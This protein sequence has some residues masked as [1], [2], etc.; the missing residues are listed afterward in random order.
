M[1]MTFPSPAPSI[2]G[3]LPLAIAAGV[4]LTAAMSTEAITVQ[5]DYTYDTGNY[6]SPGS[7][8]RDVLESAASYVGELLLDDLEAIVPD[9]PYL[10]EDD[11]NWP[12]VG[13]TWQV[14][15]RN[16]SD[17]TK[18]L[19]DPFLTV[20]A[21]T[22]IIFA[23]GYDYTTSQVAEAG[24]GGAATFAAP[25]FNTTVLTRGEVGGTNNESAPWG[26]SL[27]VDN[28]GTIWDLSVDGSTLGEGEYHLYSVMLHE[29]AHVLGFGTANSWFNRVSGGNF[30][31]TEASRVFGSPVPITGPNSDHFLDN[32]S[33][34]IYGTQIAQEPALSED[35][36]TNQIKLYT[37][38][39]LAALDD[40]GWDIAT[41]IP[42]PGTGALV[43]LLASS[44]TLRRR[45]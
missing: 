38:L 32:I 39:D 1:P 36:R 17:P 5:I 15:F 35:I 9:E 25:D 12:T 31:G 8:R 21:D 4:F 22:I 14:E 42:E 40:I 37:E 26:G 27:T 7:A 23:G 45:R 18:S 3:S 33:S 16:P 28:A 20:P 13:N 11:P 19:T 30:T 29:I 10:P 2:C 34:E 43:A 24:F 6:F 41:P 44:L